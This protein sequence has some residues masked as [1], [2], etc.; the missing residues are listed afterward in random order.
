MQYILKKQHQIAI[1]QLLDDLGIDNKAIRKKLFFDEVDIE[2]IITRLKVAIKESPSFLP[3]MAVIDG[4]EEEALKY[5]QNIIATREF[6]HQIEHQD[7]LED[8]VMYDPYGRDIFHITSGFDVIQLLETRMLTIDFADY[9]FHDARQ[10]FL[11]L[12]AHIHNSK[13]L[14]EH[15]EV[16]IIDQKSKTSYLYGHDT[17]GDFRLFKYDNSLTTMRSPLDYRE[18]LPFSKPKKIGSV[19]GYHSV[20]ASFLAGLI[21]FSHHEDIN[22]N[23]LENFDCF[24]TEL[25][26]AGQQFGN[27]GDAGQYSGVSIWNGFMSFVSKRPASIPTTE[28][29]YYEPIINSANKT[30]DYFFVDPKTSIRKLTLSISAEMLDKLIEGVFLKVQKGNGRSCVKELEEVVQYYF[31]NHIE[32]VIA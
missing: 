19:A 21:C 31:D 18:I 29:T 6:I 25:K 3:L 22:V 11:A 32:K 9:Q 28:D 23:T 5:E 15:R 13:Q 17:H 16:E 4:K 8:K 1:T 12:S 2:G 10:M 27:F 24:I 20:E 14:K 7:I 30:L 26:K